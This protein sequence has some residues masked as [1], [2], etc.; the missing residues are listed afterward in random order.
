M[1]IWLIEKTTDNIFVF[2]AMR[3]EVMA[4][5]NFGCKD[6]SKSRS[7]FPPF[8]VLGCVGITN[9]NQKPCK[10]RKTYVCIVIFERL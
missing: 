10:W 4:D 8:Y 7:P 1:H 2:N 3:S 9:E 6:V 5:H